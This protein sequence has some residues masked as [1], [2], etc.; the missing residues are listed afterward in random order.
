VRSFLLTSAEKHRPCLRVERSSGAVC[1]TGVAVYASSGKFIVQLVSIQRSAMFQK[2]VYSSA[3]DF[4]VSLKTP[5]PV[6]LPSIMQKRQT[7]WLACCGPFRSPHTTI[8]ACA[9]STD[10]S[11]WKI[12]SRST[13]LLHVPAF[14]LIVMSFRSI[15]VADA[16]TCSSGRCPIDGSKQHATRR[17]NR[18]YSALASA[19]RCLMAS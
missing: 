15:V 11:P 10:P 3:K 2:S 17:G 19:H 14:Y 8:R 1:R 13:S 5:Q 4:V 16:S 9:T 12:D 6:C 7:T 18:V